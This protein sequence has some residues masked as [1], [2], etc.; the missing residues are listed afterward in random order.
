MDTIKLLKDGEFSVSLKEG[1]EVQMPEYDGQE[2]IEVF[3][4]WVKAKWTR[5]S[6]SVSLKKMSKIDDLAFYE[7]IDVSH[8][9]GD[10]TVRNDVDGETLDILLSWDIISQHLYQYCLD[11]Q[12]DEIIFKA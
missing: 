11:E 2:E 1:T 12:V 7:H 5:I 8:S 10:L 6:L 9:R 4:T 3:S